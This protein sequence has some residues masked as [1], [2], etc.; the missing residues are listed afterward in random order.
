MLASNEFSSIL[1]AIC[2]FLYKV[3]K[4]KI[5]ICLIMLFIYKYLNI[6]ERK[7]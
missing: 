3:M 5:Y 1:L 2:I 7:T 6:F 4:N